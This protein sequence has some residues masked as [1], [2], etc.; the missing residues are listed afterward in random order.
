[1]KRRFEVVNHNWQES[2]VYVVYDNDDGD[3]DVLLCS[4]RSE[5]EGVAQKKAEWIAEC[6][7]AQE[8]T[9]IGNTTELGCS[10]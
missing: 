4:C 7:T 9:A 8:E 1:M 6:M 2:S 10:E 5:H 3:N